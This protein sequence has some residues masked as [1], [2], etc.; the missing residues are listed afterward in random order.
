MAAVRLSRSGPKLTPAYSQ[1]RLC[2]LTGRIATGNVVSRGPVRNSD[3]TTSSNDTRKQ[4]A[5]VAMI[6]DRIIGNVTRRNTVTGDAPSDVAASSTAGGSV[7]NAVDST[8]IAYG[9]VTTR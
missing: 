9:S 8:R 6:P 5:V 2:Q 4:S 3:R 1:V 7:D